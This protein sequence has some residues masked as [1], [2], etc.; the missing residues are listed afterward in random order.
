MASMWPPKKG[1][2]FTLTAFL[3]K[4]D[5]TFIANPGTLTL[6]ISK[7]Y[8][9]WADSHNSGSTPSEEDSTYG[10][11]KIALDTTDT[12]ADIIDVYLVDNTSGC[13]PFTANIHTVA[14]FQDELGTSIASILADTGTDGVVLAADAITSAKIA[15][16]AFSTEHFATD[17]ISADTLKTDAITEIQTGL[18]TSAALATV[19]SNVDSLVASVAAFGTTEDVADAVWDEALADHS[20]GVTTGAYL[21]H[22]DGVAS[23]VLEDTGTTLDTK[24]NTI[25]DFLDSEVAAIYAAVITNAA[26]TDIAADIIALKAVADVIQADTDLLDDAAGGIADIHTDVAAVKSETAELK[27]AVIT[28]AA[29]TDVAADIIALKTVADT[30]ATDT[31]TDIPALIDALPTAAEVWSNA[32]G[33]AVYAAVHTD[34]AG[35]NIAADIV[36]LKTVADTIQADTDLLDDAAGGIADIH[37]DVAAV[38]AE[39]AEL[40]AAVIT[41]AAGTDVAA[42]IIALKAVA[43]TIATDTTTDIPATITTMQGNV[44]SIL[45]DTN[46][47]QTNQGAWAT[48]TG[49]ATSAALE[50]VDN[51]IDTEV[52]AIKASVDILKTLRANKS[53][54]NAG[55]TSI[56]YYADNG[57]DVA[58]TQAWTEAT[59]TRGTYTA[60]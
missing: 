22:V 10:Q 17:S 4:S 31:T 2:A 1:A 53:V 16:D 27:A 42:D 38:K 25:D 29:G 20:A 56:T 5:G 44:T 30:I 35:T 48:A 28:N 7:D 34:A 43:D 8:G 19:D 45:A 18:A 24:L 41:N 14:N 11:I 15:D 50:T 47:L 54:E 21:A 60:S 51:F 26:G 3:Y 49:F 57:T 59:K 13:V 32:T 9:D 6:K 40:K 36:A 58:G 55:G 39:T 23:N 12:N 52:A 37:T 46:E 33:A